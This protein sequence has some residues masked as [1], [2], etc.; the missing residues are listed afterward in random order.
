MIGLQGSDADCVSSFAWFYG[1]NDFDFK[2]GCYT[3]RNIIP[4]VLHL[5][6]DQISRFDNQL[7]VSS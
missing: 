5:I 1:V 4:T 7:Y 6:Y 2:F 3:A